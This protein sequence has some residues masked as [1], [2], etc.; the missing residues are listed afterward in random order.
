M[1]A[2]S[3]RCRADTTATRFLALRGFF[4]AFIFLLPSRS[5]L[6]RILPHCC[7]WFRHSRCATWNFSYTTLPTSS[8]GAG[9]FHHLSTCDLTAFFTAFAATFPDTVFRSLLIRQHMVWVRRRT[10]LSRFRVALRTPVSP[11][12]HGCCAPGCALDATTA[13]F[14]RY[15]AILRTRHAHFA[16]RVD[17]PGLVLV[18]HA[19]LVPFVLRFPAVRARI[20]CA[21]RWVSPAGSTHTWVL[22]LLD[23]L[24]F[25]TASTVLT[26]LRAPGYSSCRT[27]SAHS[28]LR[29]LSLRCRRQYR[30]NV[31]PPFCCFWRSHVFTFHYYACFCTA[32]RF[33]TIWIFFS[34]TLR[35]S[36]FFRPSS[37]A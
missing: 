21:F 35:F 29:V 32:L 37:F 5:C 14:Y 13:P 26:V 11:T 27:V 15:R 30:M 1:N 24:V 31:S 9:A 23:F 8:T 2:D 19:L 22:A 10:V 28:T 25:N 18:H 36:W 3:A 12:C 7:R 33:T 20:R 6:P 16:W 4:T 34:G 17:I